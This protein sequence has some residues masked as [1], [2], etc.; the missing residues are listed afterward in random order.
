MV[1][2]FERVTNKKVPYK[3]MPRRAGDIA[4]SYADPQKAKQELNWQTEKGIEE[5]CED[6]WKFIVKN[7]DNKKHPNN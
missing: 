4:T 5:M 7:K 3:I 1:K 2:T 6:T